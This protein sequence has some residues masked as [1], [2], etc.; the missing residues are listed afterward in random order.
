M[1]TITDFVVGLGFD[2]TAFDRGIKRSEQTLG[3]FRSN[4]LQI[5]AALASGF[6]LKSLSF[7][8]AEQKEGIRQFAQSIGVAAEKYSALAQAAESFGASESEVQGILSQMAQDSKDYAQGQFNY[9]PLAIAGIDWGSINNAKNSLEGLMA[10]AKQWQG[11]SKNQKLTAANYYGLTPQMVDLLN[12]GEDGV[13]KLM[14]MF[15]K[16][17]PY[18]E[19]MGEAARR[20]NAEWAALSATIGGFADRVA[21]PFIDDVTDIVEAINDWAEANK[22]WLNSGAE[23]IGDHLALFASIVAAFPIAKLLGLV[24]AL[25]KIASLGS[26]IKG[27]GTG[28]LSIARAFPV[29]GIISAGAAGGVAFKNKIEG[30]DNA[31][32]LNGDGIV[33]NA[34]RADHIERILRENAEAT[35][36][37]IPQASLDNLEKRRNT[38]D[39]PNPASSKQGI[40]ALGYD[41][42]QSR[43]RIISGAK[44]ADSEKRASTRTNDK[45]T[46]IINNYIDTPAF[47]RMIV[48]LDT[49]TWN[50]ASQQSKST[51]DR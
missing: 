47:S 51:T 40:K 39:A 50:A 5:G 43:E 46:L 45:K 23:L 3:S 16:A 13:R 26:G 42:K 36:E 20:F 49:D 38:P 6:S 41:E 2:S 15:G 25:G 24:G 35:G 11:F 1:A 32:D 12:Q 48:D 34:E 44:T 31:T 10:L 7:G 37:A 27:L 19:G 4:V 22:D 18:T 9:M 17:R 30:M 14:E 28:I 33:S 8:F 21:M 29:L